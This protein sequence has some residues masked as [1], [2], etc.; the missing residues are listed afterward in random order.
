MKFNATVCL[1]SETVVRPTRITFIH[2]SVPFVRAIVMIGSCKLPP[3]I[4]I[5]CQSKC[6]REVE[7]S[8]M[9][10]FHNDVVTLSLPH[11]LRV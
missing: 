1:C 5:M 10:A 11:L 6:F 9:V 3:T 8:F 7:F 2:S 4:F